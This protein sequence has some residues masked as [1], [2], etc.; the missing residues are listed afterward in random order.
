MWFGFKSHFAVSS[1]SEFLLVNLFKSA[2]ISDMTMAIP[3]LRRLSDMGLFGNRVI[4]DK[5]YDAKAIYNEA[6]TL[7]FEP[8]IPLKRIAQNDGE[9]GNY[10]RPTCL[11]EHSYLFDSLDKR[12]GALKYIRPEA[13]CRDCPLKNEGLCQKVIK[14]KQQTDFR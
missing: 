14:V 11:L 13:H 9:V 4:F 7:G 10:Y 6:R 2:Y 1:Q 12:Y 3:I 5:G 8:F